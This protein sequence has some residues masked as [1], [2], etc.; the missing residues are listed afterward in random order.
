MRDKQTISFWN[1]N[2]SPVRQAYELALLKMLLAATNQQNSTLINDT[3]D[4]PKAEDEG[5]VFAHQT[6]ILITVAGNKKFH[7]KPLISI[8]KPICKGLL[9]QRV[10]IIRTQDQAKFAQITATQLKHKIAGIPATWV[11]ADLFRLNGYKVLEEGSLAFIFKQL[12]DKKCDYISLGIYEA[13]S[14]LDEYDHRG[15]F[16]IEQSLFI[17]YPLPLVFYIHPDQKQLA[18]Q[19]ESVLQSLEVNAD[20]EQLF[21]LHYGQIINALNIKERRQLTLKNPNIPRGLQILPTCSQ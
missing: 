3:T 11:D 18:T 20:W 10:L 12:K 9:G 17:V 19:L 16:S 13:Q 21:E 15:E 2:K 5:N 6:D 1:G 4:Y 8:K 14:L 7:N